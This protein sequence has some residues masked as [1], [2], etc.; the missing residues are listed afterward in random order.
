MASLDFDDFETPEGWDLW[1]FRDVYR[2]PK[3]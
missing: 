3:L 2:G 1:D